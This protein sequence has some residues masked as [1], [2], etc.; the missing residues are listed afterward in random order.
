MGKMKLTKDKR[1]K[2]N[3][4]IPN[5]LLV[6]IIAVIIGAVLLTCVATLI[7][8]SGLV[9]RMSN[10]VISEDYKVNGAMMQYYYMLTYQNF[11]SNYDYYLQGGYFSLSG[12][13]PAEHN[14]IVIGT[15]QYDVNFLGSYKDKDGND[16]TWFDYFMDQTVADV[17]NM[18]IYCE[19]ADRLGIS[20]TKEEKDNINAAIDANIISIKLQYGGNMSESSA[21]AA[22]YG[23]GVNRSDIRKA[24]EISTLASKCAEQIYDEIEKA[25]TDERISEEYDKNSKDYNGVDYFYYR[26][27][28]NYNELTEGYTEAQL[29]DK[30]DEILKKYA[31]KIAEVK[32]VADEA[33]KITDLKELQTFVLT[34]AANNKYDDLLADEELKSSVLPKEAELKTIKDKIVAAIVK[35]TMDGKDETANDVKETK[36][37]KT[38]TY[39]IYDISITED[40]AKAI[41]TLKSD[42]FTTIKNTKKSYTIEKANYVKD[43]AFSEWAFSADRKTGDR[44]QIEEGDSSKK[45][46]TKADKKYYYNTVYF[47]TSPSARDESN[48]RDVAYMLFS[49]KDTAEKAI[50]KL[51]ETKDLTREKFEDI[52]DDFGAATHTVWEDYLKGEMGSSAFDNWLY[53]DTTKK[54]SF[55]ATPITMSDESI[56]VAYYVEDGE[57][58]WKVEVKDA[59]INDEYEEREDDMTKAHIGSISQ[60]NWTID[61]IGK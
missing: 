12:Y 17:K 44:K 34:Y 33:A 57:V 15:S 39:S 18:L 25:V 38:T 50:K 23:T 35:D 43:D 31:E 53:A 47:L 13:S 24:M 6:T 54:G 30:K 56:M 36:T 14:K 3:S 41:K 19:E 9:L 1:K 40:F 4:G 46:E 51:G 48:S 55:T 5:W 16:G 21:L 59:I 7:A 60:S 37:D 42:L 52:A 8:N 28:V 58:V 61:L 49:S 32:A 29:K 45:G 27:S 10:A 20:L 26:F 2:G 22:M 11:A